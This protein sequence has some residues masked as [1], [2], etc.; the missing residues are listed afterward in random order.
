L[1]DALRRQDSEN[2]V[3]YAIS[4]SLA[5]ARRAP[6]APARLGVVYV[7]RLDDAAQALGL[8][9]AETGANVLLV[10][11]FDSVVFERTMLDEGL[12]YVAPSQIAADLLAS[13]GRGPEEAEALIEWM[14]SLPLPAYPSVAKTPRIV[15]PRIERLSMSAEAMEV[16][17]GK[18]DMNGTPIRVFDLAK[19]VAD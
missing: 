6:I 16:G 12:R 10:E 13:S 11:P 5:A 19:T 14:L 4:G 3:T 2:G 8:L 9:P 15:Y 18:H 7:E 1:L 17:V